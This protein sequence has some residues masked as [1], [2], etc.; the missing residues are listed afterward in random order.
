MQQSGARGFTHV[1]AIEG[2]FYATRLVI[3]TDKHA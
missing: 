1:G 2:V 3:S